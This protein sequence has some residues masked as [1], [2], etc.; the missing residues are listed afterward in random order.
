MSPCPDHVTTQ[1]PIQWVLGTLCTGLKMPEREFDHSHPPSA[2]VKNTWNQTSILSC[3]YTW[4]GIKHMDIFTFIY[5]LPYF[6][7]L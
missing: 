1:P 2:D 7:I 3:T 6:E 4:R 5:I